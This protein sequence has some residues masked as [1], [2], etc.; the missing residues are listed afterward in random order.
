MLIDLVTSS[1]LQVLKIKVLE[2]YCWKEDDKK[3]LMLQREGR[4]GKMK[5][6]NKKTIKKFILKPK[7][8][9]HK[10]TSKVINIYEYG[11]KN[12]SEML[13]LII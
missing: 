11:A 7:W 2:I 8:F 3:F 13:F 12:I 4:K 5:G 1:G 6:V 9:Q 10:Y